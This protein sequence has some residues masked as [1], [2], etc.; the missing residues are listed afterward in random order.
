MYTHPTDIAEKGGGALSRPS[1]RPTVSQKLRALFSGSVILGALDRFTEIIYRWLKTGLFAALFCAYPVRRESS[2]S[3]AR[4]GMWS[5]L[6]RSIARAMEECAA[7]RLVRALIHFLLRCRLRVYGTFL[8]SFG[9]YCALSYLYRFLGAQ[10]ERALGELPLSGLLVAVV[11]IG[12]ALPLLFSNRSLSEALL[13]SAVAAP[14]LSLLGIR[15]ESL[16][17]SGTAGRSNLA[18]VLGILAGGLTFFVPAVYAAGALVGLFVAYR[19]F[20]SPEVGVFFLFLG[21]PFLPTMALVALVCY[22]IVSYAFKLLLGKRKFHLELLD[23]AVLA[24]GAALACGGVFSFSTGSRR[25]TLVF[26]AFLGAYFLTVFMIR[27]REWLNRCAWA[28]IA[29]A[30]AVALIGI[31]QYVTG[32]SLGASAWLDAD[33]FEDIGSRVVSTLENPNMLAEYLILLF[34]LAA[35]QLLSR[36]GAK[37]RAAALLAVGAVAACIVLTWSRGAWLGLIAGGL[38]FCLIWNRRTIYLILAGVVA[39]PFLPLVLPSS[40]VS[41]FT[42]IGNL[43]DTS[44]SYRVNIWRGAVRM[45]HDYWLSGIG[46]G[47]APWYEVYPRYSLS[48]IERAPHAHNLYLQIWIELGLVGLA[49]LALLLFLYLQ[50]SF[51]FCRELSRAH[52]DLHGAAEIPVREVTAMRLEATAPMCGVVA[53]LVQGLTDY[54][55]YNYRVYLMFWLVLGLGA[56][57]IRTGRAELSRLSGRTEAPPDTAAAAAAEIPLRPRPAK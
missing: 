17:T 15:R 22:T 48:A 50:Y 5:S 45:L 41:R 44:T 26:L 24:F 34:P 49:L 8:L 27:T 53:V 36:T 54:S 29:A 13:A 6:R 28:A 16:R 46:V 11:L 23:G 19:V 42:S 52:D 38:L 57:Y 7:V 2:A 37:E 33:M 43:A 31:F 1:S 9:I 20:V 39:V 35:A 40:I 30:G 12:C 55:W 32:S 47:E 10:T 18:F 4:G 56:A 3:A 14:L 51:T 25:P 21:M